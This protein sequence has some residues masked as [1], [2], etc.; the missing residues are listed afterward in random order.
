M[1]K[2]TFALACVIGMM[3]FASCDP[4]VMEEILEQKPEVSFVSEEGYISGNSSILIG[5]ELKFK[6]AIAPNSGSLSE[7]VSFDF[8]IANASGNIVYSRNPEIIDPSNENIYVFDDLPELSASTYTVTATVTDAADKANVAT[9]IVDYV[10]PIEEGLGTFV[11]TMNIQGHLSTNEIAGQE[12]YNLDTIIPDIPVTMVLGAL[13]DNNNVRGTFY[14]EDTPVSLYGTMEN[15]VITFDEFHFYKVINLYVDVQLEYA[16]NI[17]GVLNNDNISL[18]G[19]AFG[20][21]QT[22]ILLAV[23]QVTLDGNMDGVLEK[24]VIR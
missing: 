15:N 12:A 2:L 1:K 5:T 7:L 9:V 20:T 13:D 3:F 10:L 23:L 4:E 16:M 24:E 14:V 18:G 6:V 8:S 17:T 11:G 19:T 21:G 22:Q